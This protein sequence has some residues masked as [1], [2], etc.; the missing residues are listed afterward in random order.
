[1][2]KPTDVT[3]TESAPSD[4]RKPGHDH[5]RAQF[6]SVKDHGLVLGDRPYHFVGA[7][8]WQAMNLASR[9]PG[10]NRDQLVREL[11]R[12][13]AS[14]VTNVRIIA[15]SEGPDTEPY[16][17]V[18]ALL[19]SPGEYDLA[20]LDGLDFV[21]KEMGERHMKAVM[22]LGNMWHWSGGFGQYLLWAGAAE[23]IPYP[24]PA[25]NGNWDEYQRFCA[26]FYGNERAVGYYL[27]HVQHIVARYN[28][29]TRTRY[30]DDPTI[31][32]WE[33]AN[34]PRAV[35]RLDDYRRWIAR[36]S[37]YIKTLDPQHLVTTGS[38]GD[39][40]QPSFT[41][42]E[43]YADHDV[44]TID[45]GT[46]HVWIQNWDW[47]DPAAPEDT[48]D[49]ALALAKRY[50]DSHVERTLRLNKPIVF[51]EF[52]IA[53][54]HNRFDAASSVVWRDRYYRE[55]IEHL[56]AHARMGAVSGTNFWAWSGES[57]PLEPYGSFWKPGDPFLGDPPHEQQGWYGVYDTDVS[58][59]DLISHYAELM[60]GA[61]GHRRA[62][63]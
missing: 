49:S 22:V 18:P 39:T 8:F 30:R 43:Y 10:G 24:P 32:A 5:D 57:R 26:Q 20:L 63:P 42:T 33:L 44:P 23:A 1:M 28:P 56:L 60:N 31:M 3:T 2:Q 61:Q 45:Y 46:A 13:K 15:A 17:A 37:A 27:Q 41:N 48:F 36:A 50:I 62:Q 34:E 12:L 21:L 14:G 9:G 58:T 47:Y 25:E 35:D 54:D 51:E 59:I 38:E 6:V 19:K 4:P 52:G 40:S 11:D 16:R 29:Y 53:R 7:N 55:F